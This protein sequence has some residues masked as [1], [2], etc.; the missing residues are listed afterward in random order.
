MLSY[1]SLKGD[2]T[3]SDIYTFDTLVQS[4][5]TAYEIGYVGK[6]FYLGPKYDATS[7]ES[8]LDLRYALVNIAAFLAQSQSEGISMNACDEWHSDSVDEMYQMSNACGQFGR[9]YQES[10]FSYADKEMECPVVENMKAE[11]VLS[12]KYVDSL[13]EFR[14][15]LYC[16]PDQEYTGAYDPSTGFYKNGPRANQNGRTDVKG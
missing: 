15:N 3:P 16:G 4:V 6:S 10:C 5:A 2:A 7:D 14:P 8:S 12:G 9:N 1:P 13:F 11:A